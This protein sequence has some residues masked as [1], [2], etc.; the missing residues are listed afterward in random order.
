[1]GEIPPAKAQIILSHTYFQLRPK[2]GAAGFPA[3]PSARARD[4]AASGQGPQ[5]FGAPSCPRRRGAKP[6]GLSG[7]GD[8][9]LKT[10]TWWHREA[11]LPWPLSLD[12]MS[13]GPA[14]IAAG[15]HSYQPTVAAPLFLHPTSAG[16]ISNSS[17][18]MFQGKCLENCLTGKKKKNPFPASNPSGLLCEAAPSRPHVGTHDGSPSPPRSLSQRRLAGAAEVAAL[19]PSTCCSQAGACLIW[20]SRAA[21]VPAPSL[22]Q[23]PAAPLPRGPR[24]PR[25]Q[26]IS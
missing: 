18:K 10:S 17:V 26:G 23:P 5:S 19:S 15:T 3:L 9:A 24:P 12:S 11:S 14:G 20:V 16:D 25:Y 1:M 21:C 8:T 22:H 4:A 2:Q 13:R 6:A 7:C